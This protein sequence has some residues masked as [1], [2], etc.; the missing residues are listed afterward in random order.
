MKIQFSYWIIILLIVFLFGCSGPIDESEELIVNGNFE[1]KTGDIPT[2][3]RTDAYEISRRT[4]HFSVKSG[5]AHSG[6]FYAAIENV[7][8]ADSR[9]IQNVKVEPNSYYKLSGWL[10]GEDV[11]SD[12]RGPKGAN[13]SIIGVVASTGNIKNET[14]KWTY[15]E[16]YG[17]TGPN[18]H[19]LTVACRLGGYGEESI[20]KA[21]FDDISLRRLGGNP[22]G[23]NVENFYQDKTAKAE[24][25]K[26]PLN[27]V[28][29]RKKTNALFWIIAFSLVFLG[30]YFFLYTFFLKKDTLHLEDQTKKILWLF[31][32]FITIAFI[33]RIII[34]YYIEG[35]SGDLS[36]FKGWGL[37]A[38]STPWPDYYDYYSAYIDK[39]EYWCDYPPVYIMI[40]S[41]LAWIQKLFNLGTQ[42]FTLLIKMPN[43]ISDIICCY[44]I[45]RI[46]KRHLH[47][48]GALALSLLYAFN[49]AIIINSAV[50]GQADAIYTLLALLIVIFILDK[51]PWVFTF[52]WRKKQLFKF[53]VTSKLWLSGIILGIALLIKIQTGFVAFAGIFALIERKKVIDWVSTLGLSLGIFILF[54][55]P[56]GI[57]LP[58]EWI[59]VQLIGT[60]TGYPYASVNA[61]NFFALF[62]GNWLPTSQPFLLGFSADVW[63]IVIG[64]LLVIFMI[65]IYFWSKDKSKN[66]Y[67]GFFAMAS[68]FMFIPGMHERYHYA[69]IIFS[70]MTYIY[71]KDRRFLYLFLGFS[72]SVFVNVYHILDVFIVAEISKTL[73]SNYY[74]IQPLKE[75]V[76]V[77]NALANLILFA[78][79]IKVGVD[80]YI[81]RKLIVDT[82]AV[83]ATPLETSEDEML[84]VQKKSSP[85]E[86]KKQESPKR[87]PVFVMGI[88]SAFV[89]FL[90]IYSWVVGRKEMKAYPEDNIL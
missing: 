55:L 7:T 74:P 60:L 63:G 61:Y 52:S 83:Y 49:P 5:S 71:T 32:I 45:Y 20:G 25:A 66:Y 40:L 3:W 89:P 58:F 42:G 85:K 21:Y 41:V 84:T 27:V 28:D 76:L 54:T 8:A 1:N 75:P 31:V 4:I 24:E 6:N 16:L 29:A 30:L 69:T 87:L 72:I 70:I 18:Q 43:I 67:I 34:G 77:I 68:V 15:V 53:T 23:K 33:I 11:P 64:Y 50:W 48:N 59:I 38:A 13:I 9:L 26:V 82:G 47:N 44:L 88:L 90:G 80:V 65:F 78:Y 36:C 10:K 73:A 51:K 14:D 62:G 56:F 57:K 12:G 39:A 46:A 79:L 17:K 2:A 37:H 81:R 19:T 22:L 86:K 35:M